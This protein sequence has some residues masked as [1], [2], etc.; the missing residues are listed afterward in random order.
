MF[1]DWENPVRTGFI[2]DAQRP[3]TAGPAPASWAV[4]LL[5]FCCGAIAL[6]LAMDG[7]GFVSIGAL[8]ASY[9]AL[10]AALV[11]LAIILLWRAARVL[12]M[13]HR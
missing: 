10:V 5:V 7:G 13:M 3:E 9:W 1:R 12:R 11:S 2:D 6:L 4:H 8:Q